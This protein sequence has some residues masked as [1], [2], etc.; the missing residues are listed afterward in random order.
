M[1][2]TLNSSVSDSTVSDAQVGTLPVSPQPNSSGSSTQSN[3]INGSGKQYEVDGAAP[4]DLDMMWNRWKCLVCGYVYEGT[5]FL[6][7]CPKCGN[8]DPD[9]FKS[10]D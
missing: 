8:E 2:N 9:K 1:A 10:A 3:V 5:K 4:E 6:K 7:K